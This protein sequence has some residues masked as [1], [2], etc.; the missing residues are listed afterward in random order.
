MLLE[1]AKWE[2][3]DDNSY[4]RLRLYISCLVCNSS[5]TKRVDPSD[6]GKEDLRCPKCGAEGTVDEVQ[7]RMREERVLTLQIEQAEKRIADAK[8]LDELKKE[9][10]ELKKNE[11]KRIVES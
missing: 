7:A 1:I 4:R 6:P 8:R 11:G 9:E 10:A 2:T 5:W 3:V